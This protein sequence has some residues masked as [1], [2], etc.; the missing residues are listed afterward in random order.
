MPDIHSDP[1]L[2]ERCGSYLTDRIIEIVLNV[3]I[4]VGIIIINLIIRYV[5]YALI[6]AVKYASKSEYA[7]KRT[8]LTTIAVY[9][10]TSFVLFLIFVKVGDFSIVEEF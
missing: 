3:S 5:V 9:L 7:I 4:A 6:K 10:N 2:N 1:T 8:I